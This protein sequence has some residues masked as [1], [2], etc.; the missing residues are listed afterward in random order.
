MVSEI[1]DVLSL[2]GAARPKALGF[3]TDEIQR[4]LTADEPGDL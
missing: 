1:Y 4:L 2:P 3:K